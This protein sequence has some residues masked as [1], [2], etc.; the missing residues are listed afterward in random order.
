MLPLVDSSFARGWMTVSDW[1]VIECSPVRM[2]LS[3]ILDEEDALTG[4]CGPELETGG[5]MERRLLLVE[6]EMLPWSCRE[7]RQVVLSAG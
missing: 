3:E 7:L 2:L 4:A 5:R 6:V 1:M